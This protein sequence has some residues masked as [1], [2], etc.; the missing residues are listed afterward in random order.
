MKVTA[1]IHSLIPQI[2]IEHLLCE[3]ARHRPCSPIADIL[4]GDRK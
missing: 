1:F 3:P 2:S 4:V